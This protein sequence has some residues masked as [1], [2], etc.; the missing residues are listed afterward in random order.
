M[1]ITNT[2]NEENEKNETNSNALKCR[3][4]NCIINSLEMMSVL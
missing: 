4:M 3:R 1:K 2:L